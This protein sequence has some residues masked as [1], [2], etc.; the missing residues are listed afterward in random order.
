MG[1]K[2]ENHAS[3]GRV[4]GITDFESPGTPFDDI[5]HPKNGPGTIPGC[6]ADQVCAVGGLL[7][8]ELTA[9]LKNPAPAK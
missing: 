6:P 7:A 2:T 5:G 1:L 4:T 9:S 3:A 8:A